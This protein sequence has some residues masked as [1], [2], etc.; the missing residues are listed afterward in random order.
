MSTFIMT[1]EISRDKQET[2]RK[3]YH[4]YDDKTIENMKQYFKIEHDSD[5]LLK[6]IK[7]NRVSHD[8]L[9]G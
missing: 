7:G 2:N 9:V 5:A 4:V 3:H 1:S 6:Y 8:V